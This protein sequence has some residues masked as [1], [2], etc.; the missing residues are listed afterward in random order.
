INKDDPNTTDQLPR[1]TP[2]IPTWEHR[3]AI[4]ASG[5]RNAY[6]K[7]A[8]AGAAVVFPDERENENTIMARLPAASPQTVRAADLY[9]ILLVA[10]DTES[11]V[12]L[13][14]ETPS[15]FV[16]EFL[17]RKKDTLEDI[18][19][20][21]NELAPLMREVIL[22][23]RNRT[24]R[25]LFRL[26]EGTGLG[27]P[28]LKIA[29]KLAK[30]AT[31]SDTPDTN[32]AWPEPR[33]TLTGLKLSALTQRLAH[34]SIRSAK[35]KGQKDRPRTK[36]MLE[37]TQA[38]I[39]E[40]FQYVPE[41]Q[42]IWKALR[43]PEFSKKLRQFLWMTAH[44]AYMVGDKWNRDS[45]PV[46]VKN[47]RWCEHCPGKEESMEHIL[48]Q[49]ESPGQGEV[50]DLAETVWNNKCSETEW[51]KPGIDTIIGAGLAKTE[52]A[53]PS[54]NNSG[55]NRLWRILIAE[56]A[57][58]IWVM[59]CE[60]ILEKE[61]T[62][63]SENEVRAR[64]RTRMNGRIALDQRLTNKKYGP[65]AVST[66]T[67]ENTWTGTIHEETQL[68]DKWPQRPGVLVGIETDLIRKAGKRAKQGEG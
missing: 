45:Y 55:E 7:N 53:K 52:K 23:L 68:P 56:S 49:C 50:W 34:R 58:L 27:R 14:I 22:V 54:E 25:T 43:L 30:T 63:F 1:V 26:L 11:S 35:S 40:V 66:Y 60:R 6:T 31:Q 62:A 64:W 57:H 28:E 48:T 47:R 2:Q 51:F 16:T 65:K 18:N 19:F 46:E 24:A 20:I 67:V 17:A 42:A 59:R 15:K 12:E 8:T 29:R 39:E 41:E 32:I 37:K 5:C 38:Q 13:R 36:N 10:K 44:D 33:L 4:V 3:K 21:D 61:N 9:S